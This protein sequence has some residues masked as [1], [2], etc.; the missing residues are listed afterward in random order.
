MGKTVGECA[1]AG[2]GFVLSVGEPL[3]NRGGNFGEGGMDGVERG[4]IF[5][6]DEGWT[7]SGEALARADQSASNGLLQ[8]V[9]DSSPPTRENLA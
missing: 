5:R 2:V 8:I 7:E 9:L 3:G 6:V 1:W 4:G